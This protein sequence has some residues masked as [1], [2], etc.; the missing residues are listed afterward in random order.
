[1]TQQFYSFII[2]WLLNSLGIW[3]SVRLLS[4]GHGDPWTFLLAGILFSIINAVLKPI[5]VIL[6]L[7]AILLTLG[8]F[9]LIVNGVLVYLALAIT[10][11]DMSFWDSVLAGIIL[12]LVN[13]I[14]S[15]I[16]DLR[17]SR[18]EA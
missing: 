4:D 13:F 16:L 2:R 15:G 14:V 7:P 11:L 1:M 18:R 17:G 10:G 9:T 6:S 12:S 3:I 8:L 5:L